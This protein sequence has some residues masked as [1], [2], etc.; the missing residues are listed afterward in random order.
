MSMIMILVASGREDHI[1]SCFIK[2][3][4]AD[5]IG[6]FLCLYSVVV[7]VWRTFGCLRCL[8]PER[9]CE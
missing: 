8:F 5:S 2:P 4:Y 7:V 9:M 3:D 1:D 6:F